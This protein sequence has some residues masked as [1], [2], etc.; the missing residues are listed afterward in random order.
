MK[1]ATRLAASP[2]TSILPYAAAGLALLIFVVDTITDLEI[3]VAVFYIAVVL[4]SVSFL[5]KRGV[6]LVSL[7]CMALT[8][9]SF[10]LT[11]KGAQAGGICQLHD[12]LFGH[13]R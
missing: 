9:V 13:R 11:P 1:H 4:L 3:A 2:A 5:E 12:Q 6:V 10:Y 8:L 7:A